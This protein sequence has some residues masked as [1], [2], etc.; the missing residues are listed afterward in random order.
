[1][2]NLHADHAIRDQIVSI[3]TGK[4]QWRGGSEAWERSTQWPEIR[5]ISATRMYYVARE[6]GSSDKAYLLV[7]DLATGALLHRSYI[8][9][10]RQ[11]QKRLG[12]FCVRRLGNR[13]VLVAFRVS[14]TDELAPSPYSAY[15]GNRT[16]VGFLVINP[17][18]GST[19]QRFEAPFCQ[20]KYRWGDRHYVESR[21][22]PSTEDEGDFAVVCGHITAAHW[23]F[24]VERFSANADGTFQRIGTDMITT[25]R[26][27]GIYNL[28][29]LIPDIDPFNSM[30]LDVVEGC[31][32]PRIT[33]MEACRQWDI[34]DQEDIPRHEG[35][36]VD[37]WF[38]AGK[39]VE[40][41]C[42]SHTV[43][44]TGRRSFA[45]PSAIYRLRYAGANRLVVEPTRN[46]ISNEY[47]VLLDFAFRRI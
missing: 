47:H 26:A 14:A 24:K 40:I 39:Q 33:P 4:R 16:V 11:L 10:Y 9:D 20:D 3:S 19:L 2:R 29:L 32:L 22:I 45:L 42:P 30:C 1:M 13:E 15:V 46:F 28:E 7:H 21:M 38:R 27:V 5:G 8:T 36:Q 34:S 31:T 37:R 6:K 44:D 43:E 23:V 41:T 17:E 18:D 35:V 12:G 25:D